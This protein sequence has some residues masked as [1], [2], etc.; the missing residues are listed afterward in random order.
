MRI[1]VEVVDAAGKAVEAEVREKGVAKV[2]KVLACVR[3]RA[4]GDEGQGKSTQE[5]LRKTIP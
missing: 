1:E 4:D 2:L 3:V 5:E